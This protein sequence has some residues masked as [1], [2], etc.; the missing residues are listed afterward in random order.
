M[1]LGL[2]TSSLAGQGYPDR[3]VIFCHVIK[4]KHKEEKAPGPPSFVLVC[5]FC[6]SKHLFNLHSL[7]SGYI[8]GVIGKGLLGKRRISRGGREIGEG[9]GAK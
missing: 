6:L 1:L 2:N 9:N 7:K 8:V 3:K 4:K 5:S